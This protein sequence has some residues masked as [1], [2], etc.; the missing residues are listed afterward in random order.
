MRAA[1][2]LTALVAVSMLGVGA[3]AQAEGPLYYT[4]AIIIAPPGLVDPHDPWS[5]LTGGTPAAQV[6]LVAEN[7]RVEIARLTV[8]SADLATSL[9]RG[10]EAL[11]TASPGPGVESDYA[12]VVIGGDLRAYRCTPTM[13]HEVEGGG[14]LYTYN[15]VPVYAAIP[16]EAAGGRAVAYYYYY[17]E[18]A[19]GKC[20]DP[21]IDGLDQAL[22]FAIVAASSVASVYGFRHARR[23]LARLYG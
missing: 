11:L 15:G 5:V 3:A 20:S 21:L 23:P 4:G 7:G 18:H 1:A 22:V 8:G 17:L 12:H 9:K 19:P 13:L 14:V 16:V 2:L 10:L 6:L